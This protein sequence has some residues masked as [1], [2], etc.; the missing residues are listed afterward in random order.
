[1]INC[2]IQTYEGDIQIYP[3]KQYDQFGNR[4]NFHLEFECQMTSL[5][6]LFIIASIQL[7]RL[8]IPIWNEKENAQ[9][10]KS[11]RYSP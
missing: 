8:E 10:N 9:N 11:S 2:R 4:N 6:L 7:R 5:F 3:N 1:M